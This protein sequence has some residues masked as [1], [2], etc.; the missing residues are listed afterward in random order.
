MNEGG[1][2]GGVKKK[3]CMSPHFGQIIMLAHI[4]ISLQKKKQASQLNSQD[5]FLARFL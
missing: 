3:T 5:V 4:I 1:G 2:G